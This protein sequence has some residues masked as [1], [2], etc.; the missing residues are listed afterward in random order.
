MDRKKLE[1]WRPTVL[2]VLGVCVVTV[3]V[4]AFMGRVWWCKCGSPVPWAWEI[5]SMH[6]SQ[7]ILDPYAFT[8]VLHG[9]MFYGLL[10]IVLRGKYPRLGPVLAGVLEGAWEIL[11]NTPWIIDKYRENTVSLDYYGDSIAN[12]LSD[13]ACC[14]LGYVVARRLPWWG[15]LLLFVGIELAMVAAIKDSLLLNVLMLVY[16]LD[17]VKAWQAG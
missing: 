11:E 16:P 14:G 4:L 5:W 10:F 12:S 3:V 9:V 1:Y 7:H 6:N 15:T 17:A 8:H 13:L 2:G